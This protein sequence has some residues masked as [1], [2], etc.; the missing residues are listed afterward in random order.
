MNYNQLILDIIAADRGPRQLRSPLI[1]VLS[2]GGAAV[3]HCVACILYRNKLFTFVLFCKGHTMGAIPFG[4]RV[5]SSR[6]CNIEAHDFLKS[7]LS[8]F[9]MFLF[10][11]IIFPLNKTICVHTYKYSFF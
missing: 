9:S 1:L 10:S 3:F 4:N 2:P 8:I 5:F 6:Y 11:N 7:H